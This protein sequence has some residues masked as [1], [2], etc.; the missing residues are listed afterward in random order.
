LTSCK[1]RWPSDSGKTGTDPHTTQPATPKGLTPY[2]GTGFMMRVGGWNDGVD[3]D[4]KAG[5]KGGGRGGDDPLLRAQGAPA[6][7]AAID[8][9][10]FI[11][12]A[13]ELGFTLK[14]IGELLELRIRPGTTCR[15][16]SDQATAKIAGIEEKIRSLEAMRSALEKLAADCPASGPTSECP[17]LAHM[18]HQLP[19]AA[20]DAPHSPSF[21]HLGVLDVPSSTPPRPSDRKRH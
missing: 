19:A 6:G 8:R 12:R 7:T 11:R 5:E 21:S 2:L 13:K 18:S 1:K 10:R 20:G 17:I 3:D 4:R 14:E 15:Q 16:I 9:V